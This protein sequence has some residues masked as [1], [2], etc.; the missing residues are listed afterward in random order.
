MVKSY[1]Y[2][3]LGLVDPSSITIILPSEV[4]TLWKP[5]LSLRSF[6]F[7]NLKEVKLFVTAI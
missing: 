6:S 3:A 4:Q 5:Y 7:A 2:I 1:P